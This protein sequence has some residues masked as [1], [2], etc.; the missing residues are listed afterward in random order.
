[1][2][3][4]QPGGLRYG[5]ADQPGLAEACLVPQMDNARRFECDLAPYPRL[6]AIDGARR[7]R[8]AFRRAAPEAQPDYPGLTLTG[9]GPEKPRNPRALGSFGFCVARNGR[10]CARSATLSTSIA[11]SGKIVH[12][13]RRPCQVS[14]S[15]AAQE[16]GR[17]GLLGIRWSAAG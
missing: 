11:L 10:W 8:D 12:E 7:A 13:F 2:D 6:V 16:F 1:M 9:T 5:F 3:P 15:R 4:R 17:L 14:P